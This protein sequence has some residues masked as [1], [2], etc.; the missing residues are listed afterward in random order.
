MATSILTGKKGLIIP[1]VAALL[2]VVLTY[3]YIRQKERDLGFMAQGLPVLMAKKDIPKNTR[4]DESLVEVSTIP[5]RF[6]QPGALNAID[7]AI[8]QVTTV[9]ILKGEQV[10]GT[11]L[12]SFGVETGLAIKIPQDYRAVTMATDDISGVAGLIKPG[13]SVD[14]LGTFE[15]GDRD[16]SNQRTYTLLQNVL[17]L[18][19]GQDLGPVSDAV[20]AQKL[21][22]QNAQG[23]GSMDQNMRRLNYASRQ[24]NVTLSLS[25]QQAQSLVLAQE[26]GRV[27]LVLRPMFQSD[28]KASIAPTGVQELLGVKEKVFFRPQP[29]WREIR[30][31]NVGGR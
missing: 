6:V 19:V 16:K 13:N 15:F 25:P 27:S 11:K 2:A 24:S 1:I 31:T 14:V 23:L 17:V 5:R 21:Q 28:K 9:P 4:L 8:D 10:L 7:A 30:G 22:E 12:I 26:A 29:A 3:Q 20:R 18:A